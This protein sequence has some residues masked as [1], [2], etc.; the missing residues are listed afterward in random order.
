[1]HKESPETDVAI[2]VSS[3]VELLICKKGTL[4]LKKESPI[5]RAFFS[6]FEGRI[7][8]QRIDFLIEC[9]QRLKTFAD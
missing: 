5:Q 1:M 4:W 2:G 6:I 9:L 3:G 8:K 7:T